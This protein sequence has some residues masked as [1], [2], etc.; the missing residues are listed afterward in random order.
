MLMEPP[1]KYHHGNLREAL[2]RATL[3]LL[4]AGG[5]EDVGLRDSARVVRVSASAAYRHFENKEELLAAV[6]A[7][8]FRELAATLRTAADAPDPAIA[9]GFAYVEFALKRRGL[10]CLMFGPTLLQKE[11]YPALNKAVV[12]AGEAVAR[13]S[14]IGND[15]QALERFPS[16]MNRRGFP[17]QGCS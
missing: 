5:I 15:S 8:G 6:A 1:K 12:E 16:E 13:S 7:E 4:D 2:C 17:N 3:Q 11:E 9:V 14:V 10:F